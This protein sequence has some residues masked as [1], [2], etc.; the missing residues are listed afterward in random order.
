VLRRPFG[1]EAEPAVADALDAEA[2]F[3][4]GLVALEAGDP[5]AATV[6]LRRALYVDPTFGLAAFTLGRAHETTGEINAAR[7]A[8]EQALRTIDLADARHDHLLEQVQL[9]DVATACR[10]RLGAL[11]ERA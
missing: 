1:R 5:T 8:Y 3:L 11:R 2:W 7:H 4:K 10:V 6:S 9:E